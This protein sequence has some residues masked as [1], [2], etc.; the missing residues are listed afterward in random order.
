[1]LQKAPPDQGGSGTD[2]LVLA[3][4]PVI[5]HKLTGVEA[6]HGFQVFK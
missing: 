1:M 5:E 3:A 4:Y 6:L 2:P